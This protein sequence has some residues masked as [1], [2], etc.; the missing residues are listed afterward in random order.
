MDSQVIIQSSVLTQAHALVCPS[1]GEPVFVAHPDRSE[2]PGGGTWL[3]DGDTVGGLYQLL[4]DEQRT[5]SAFDCE[6]LVGGC[7][8]CG[9][10]YYVTVASF[11]DADYEAVDAYLCFNTDLGPERNFLCSLQ[12][13]SEGVPT[14]WVMHEYSTQ[15]GLMHHHVFGPWALEDTDGVIGP[16]GVSMCGHGAVAD[17][18]ANARTLLHTTWD[19]LRVL[20]LGKPVSQVVAMDA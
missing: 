20:R 13:P 15:V 12:A 17:P 6:L 10:D 9:N 1:C 16:H 18:W 14:Q 3:R 19:A 11:M 4:T 2:V 5:P 7:R 8:S